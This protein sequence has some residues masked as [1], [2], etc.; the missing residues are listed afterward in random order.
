MGSDLFKYCALKNDST[1]PSRVHLANIDRVEKG[2]AKHE[3]AIFRI[4][5]HYNLSGD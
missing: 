2:E 3:F 1:L 5:A 4:F